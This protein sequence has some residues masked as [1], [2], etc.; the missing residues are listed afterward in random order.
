MVD[1]GD[2]CLPLDLDQ[3]DDRE[4]LRRYTGRGVTAVTEP[5]GGPD[6]IQAVLP[7]PAGH[8]LLELVVPLAPRETVPPPPHRAAVRARDSGL[9]LPG[10]RWLSLAIR[11]PAYQLLLPNLASLANDLAGHYDTWFWLRYHTLEHG[12]HIRARF[13]GDPATLGGRVLPALSA[14][15]QEMIR[16]RLSG[17][18]TV[19]PYDQE[20]ERY[21]GPAAIGAAKHVFAADSSLVLAILASISDNDQRLIIATLSAAA[22]ARPMTDAYQ[23]ALDGRHVDRATRRHML[24]LRPQ[25]RARRGQVS[26][27]P[28]LGAL[29]PAWNARRDALA[30]YRELLDPARRADCTS[31]LIH[32]HLNRLL[33]DMRSERMVRALAA[34][35][36]ATPS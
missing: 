26:A 8:H 17:G 12:P 19:E 32:M 25:V 6:A 23:A 4:L 22:I 34:D 15:C 36:L 21:G 24:D 9:H 11:T 18:F 29:R 16:Q 13:R 3:A 30:S 33:G 35:L 14:W 20:I 2:R 28:D 7:G 27:G 5:P 31:S 10:G 1:D